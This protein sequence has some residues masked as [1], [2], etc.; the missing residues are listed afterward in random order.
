MNQVLEA[1]W[2]LCKEQKEAEADLF[3][4]V[5]EAEA[6]QLAAGAAPISGRQAADGELYANQ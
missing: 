2:E 6:I 3:Q 4:K 1:N 5:K